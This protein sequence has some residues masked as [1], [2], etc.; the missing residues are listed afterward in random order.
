MITHST[1]VS[2]ALSSRVLRAL[3]VFELEPPGGEAA[4]VLA[5]AGLDDWT[6][7]A[8]GSWTE[9]E[10]GG[11]NN[12]ETS[13]VR[14]AGGSAARIDKTSAAIV[15]AR[16]DFSLAPGRWYR[17]EMWTK[18]SAPTSSFLARLT[19]VTQSLS[20]NA[21]AAAWG[22]LGG[23]DSQLASGSAY[24]RTVLWFHTS[25]ASL[26]STDTYRLT[27]WNTA[28][29]SGSY[30]V[31]DVSVQGPYSR[32]GLY[33]SS[34]A[35]T[36]EGQAF[37]AAAVKA[38][39]VRDT[40]ALVQPKGELQLANAT[41]PLRSYIEPEDLFADGRLRQRL[42]I[43]DGNLD[44]TPESLVFWQGAMRRARRGDDDTVTLPCVGL[45]NPRR[46]PTPSRRL[47]TWCQV[48]KF[49]DG[50]DCGYTSTTTTTNSNTGAASTGPITV[51][52][53]ADLVDGQALT[54]G[55][56]P[57][58][59]LVSGG[60]T[61]SLTVD[62]AIN[63][64]SSDPVR[65]SRCDR[66]WTS[67]EKRARTHEYQGF[68]AVKA[69]ARSSAGHVA[70]A[71]EEATSQ[72]EAGIGNPGDHIVLRIKSALAHLPDP[73]SIV[74][75]SVFADPT[76]VVPILI[77]RRWISGRLV[78]SLRAVT[79][80]GDQA[81]DVEFH[82]LAEGEIEDIVQAKVGDELFTPVFSGGGMTHGWYWR[83]G[84]LGVTGTEDVAT[85]QATPSVKKRAQNTDHRTAT[86]TTLSRAA[87]AIALIG[88][89]QDADISS[90]LVW[91]VKGMKLQ[92]Y[93]ATGAADGAE[94]YS[95][96]PLWACVRVA[97]ARRFALNLGAGELDMAVIKSE[98]DYCDGV[99]T[100]TLAVT[101]TTSAGAS[102]TSVP[103][104]HTEGF[105]RGQTVDVGANTGLTVESID[106]E[107]SITVD[108]A[109]TYGNGDAVQGYL[110]RFEA[111]Y[112][113]DDPAEDGLNVL[114]DLLACARGYVTQDH[115]TGKTQFRVE[116]DSAADVL[117]NGN[118]DEWT[119]SIPDGWTNT[120]TGGTVSE[121]TTIVH[122]AGGSAAKLTRTGPGA[123][124]I[125]Q[126]GVTGLAPG[127]WYLLTG[128][129]RCD[130]ALSSAL[131]IAIINNGAGDHWEVDAPPSG[132][133][134]EWDSG[135]GPVVRGVSFDLLADTWVKVRVPFQ[136]LPTH[137]E[138]DNLRIRLYAGDT[139]GVNQTLYLD[140]FK[141]EG[142]LA[143]YFRDS[144]ELWPLGAE[145]L[146]NGG[147][148]SWSAGVP[149]S[150]SKV[151]SGGAVTEDTTAPRAGSSAAKVEHTGAGAVY[152][153]QDVAAGLLPGRVYEIGFWARHVSG[154]ISG[155][156]RIR[157]WNMDEDRYLD[158]DG[159][160]G[161][162]AS[163][164][165]AVL[166]G[167]IETGR[168]E[169]FAVRFTVDASFNAHDTFRV[170]LWANSDESS[171]VDYDD[172]AL[173][174][175]VDRT[176]LTEPGHGIVLGTFSWLNDDD[177]RRDVNM[178]SV[179]FKNEDEEG[180][181]DQA[182]ENDF[183]AQKKS[184]VVK[185]LGVRMDAV[186][187]MDQASRLARYHLRKA[188]D[189]GGGARFR[190]G[191]YGLLAQPGDPVAV[192]HENPGW[193]CELK[194]ITKKESA[195]LGSARE[196]TSQ[197]EVEDYDVGIYPDTAKPPT[198]DFSRPTSSITLSAQTLSVAGQDTGSARRI[199]LTWRIPARMM[200]VIG[201]TVHRST[202]PGFTPTSATKVADV[203]RRLFTYVPDVSEIG[204]TI[205]FKV[206]ARLDRGVVV[207][208]E[209]PTFVVRIVAVEHDPGSLEA[210]NPF[211]LVYDG[212]FNDAAN[213]NTNDDTTPSSINPTTDAAG[214]E[215]NNFTSRGNA[216]DD[217]V[218]TASTG[219]A[220][221]SSWPSPTIANLQSVWSFAGVTPAVKS[222][223]LSIIWKMAHDGDGGTMR[224]EYSTNAGSS[225][226]QFAQYT[227]TPADNQ[228]TET[229]SLVDIDIEDLRV[230]VT[231][232]PAIDFGVSTSHLCSV[233]EIDFAEATGGTILS[234]VGGGLA[235]L[236]K[237]S[238]T[239]DAEVW[240]RF[241]GSNPGAQFLLRSGE[242]YVTR[243]R[244]ARS[245][246]AGAPDDDIR[247]LLRNANNNADTLTLMTIPAADITAAE[248]EF[249]YRYTA[250]QDINGLWDIV[251]Q[252]G[253]SEAVEVDRLSVQ[254]GEQLTTAMTSVEE[255]VAGVL[256]DK[257]AGKTGR[258]A[259]GPWGATPKKA[260]VT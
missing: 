82:A 9:T 188:R 120:T 159:T 210:T 66:E 107:G 63:W 68:R 171:Q 73:Y 34:R 201:Y 50:V 145:T 121:E 95:A 108:S 196:F 7:S 12:E 163:A 195:G 154:P 240:R 183:V 96:N 164:K 252:S 27:I 228:E 83:P 177:E 112:F 4:E 6:G 213:W 211:N 89:D 110:P 193:D 173:R 254:E 181:R 70:R 180:V 203:Q 253:S 62:T 176:P 119:A 59:T 246:G 57:E 134:P 67:C 245:G 2:R 236:R 168:W 135:V 224:A 149:S 151:T 258:F 77:G 46:V 220:T 150:W 244:A 218:G 133:V 30:Y 216:Y 37:A 155:S 118:L 91:D 116:R 88:E 106:S 79:G 152:M 87:Y 222:G 78:E 131:E 231:A 100:S 229:V 175:P 126:T 208:N 160:W 129:V 157:I 204:T 44:P 105:Y 166:G 242:S 238:G 178:V 81:V 8:P 165:N 113:K 185:S 1:A 187:H 28:D 230:R 179:D 221:V 130:T 233:Y 54:I 29:A 65:Y 239:D 194:R 128:W 248:Q 74:G 191:W 56:S 75:N 199:R 140:D 250:A 84:S 167:C 153:Y 85:Y 93:L 31:D 41:R 36:W 219:L 99:V 104:G 45:L 146:A 234:A 142:P 198:A 17:L 192:R 14:T 147:L 58:V 51:A 144:D 138:S 24:S 235:V 158:L 205:Y 114:K 13:D 71:F 101:T 217:N 22:A 237:D 215:D 174:G 255:V 40:M 124:R 170:Q 69:A 92:K 259:P 182:V 86:G 97:T 190:A 122:T 64:A 206:K 60:G 98:A 33:Y 132:G 226:T 111:H 225:W 61:G 3:T 15:E 172:V 26:K 103:L 251:V 52:S 115:A 143:G 18:A 42:V 207:S 16:Q 136:W 223:T 35:V 94:S 202:S 10:T 125:E 257:T 76:K 25:D 109:I 161:A 102:T 137:T 227:T 232:F 247:V 72:S 212:D 127:A 123:L 80:E 38:A 200:G 243:L 184:G 49:A 53:G 256:P 48:R 141:I 260:T 249:A 241:P 39:E 209:V 186:G 55:N 32:P 5:N 156:P 148:E 11:S 19:N 43:L 169:F 197:F 20:W 90:A 189:L 214:V 21:S 47:T 139:T 23:G 117:T 162:A